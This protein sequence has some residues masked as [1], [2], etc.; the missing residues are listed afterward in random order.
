MRCLA[1]ELA[2][3]GAGIRFIGLAIARI[4]IQRGQSRSVAGDLLPKFRRFE[5]FGLVAVS[6]NPPGNFAETI[7]GDTKIE[8]AVGIPRHSL[9]LVPDDLSHILRDLRLEANHDVCP[10]TWFAHQMP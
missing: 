10:A 4:G 6:E 5:D 9:G 2:A 1:L 8:R 7:D 3:S